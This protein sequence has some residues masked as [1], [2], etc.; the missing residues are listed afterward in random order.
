MQMNLISQKDS[1]S[2]GYVVTEWLTVV[3]NVVYCINNNGFICIAA[4]ML[5]YTISATQDSAYNDIT[6]AV[7]HN[8][9]QTFF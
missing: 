1:S 5:D 8:N 2:P 9:I 6:Y 4:R 3:V 7:K